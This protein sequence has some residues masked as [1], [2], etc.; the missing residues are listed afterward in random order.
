MEEYLITSIMYGFNP[1]LKIK[2]PKSWVEEICTRCDQ[3]IIQVRAHNNNKLCVDL[4]DAKM[5]LQKA[6]DFSRVHLQ[7]A[8]TKKGV[9]SLAKVVNYLADK[10]DL[11]EKLYQTSQA[12]AKKGVKR[13][14]VGPSTTY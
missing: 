2:E 6:F 10:L 1:R 14:R 3:M 11:A 4:Y 13:K 12:L 8:A 5:E 9:L 7:N